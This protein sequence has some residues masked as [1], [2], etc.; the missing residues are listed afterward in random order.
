ML[1]FLVFLK[2]RTQYFAHAPPFE[3][4]RTALQPEALQPEK[5]VGGGGRGGVGNDLGVQSE[6]AAIVSEGGGEELE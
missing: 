1:S 3:G 2:A 6:V 4:H 5:E